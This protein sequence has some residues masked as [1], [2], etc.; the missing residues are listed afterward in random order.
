M[1]AIALLKFVQGARVG[2]DGHALIVDGAVQVDISNGG[3]N[4]DVK[5][6]R[7]EL[8]DGPPGGSFEQIPGVPTLLAENA[9]SSIPVADITPDTAMLPGSLRIRL[10]VWTGTNFGGVLDVD[11][12]NICVLTGANRIVLPPY[13][14]LPEPLPLLG[15][16]LPGEKPD[17]M[18]FEGQPWGW[19]GSN[20][21][22]PVYGQTYAQFRL[23]NAS[24][25]FLSSASGGGAPGGVDRD[26]QFNDAGVFG[27]SALLKYLQTG[28]TALMQ[29]QSPDASATFVGLGFKNAAAVDRG[30]VYYDEVNDRVVVSSSSAAEVFLLGNRVHAGGLQLTD[31]SNKVGFGK[32]FTDSINF[33]SQNGRA[34]TY[35]DDDDVPL[36]SWDSSEDAT[37]GA[38][39]DF[40]VG[41][42]KPEGSVSADVGAVYFSVFTGVDGVLDGAVWRNTDGATSWSANQTFYGQDGTSL[43]PAPLASSVNA[44]LADAAALT[45]DYEPPEGSFERTTFLITFG[46]P[47][48]GDALFAFDHIVVTQ[49][50]GSNAPTI[51]V[52]KE[53]LG[54]SD[55][56]VPPTLSVG[57]SIN[58]NNV[59]CTV[60][61]NDGAAR[62]VKIA[63]SPVSEP[64]V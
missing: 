19:S 55:Y 18:N 64:L 9:N 1:A 4:T 28:T 8:L 13:Q 10:S 25:A 33:V 37:N 49:R 46:Q 15:S 36:Q 12:R 45:M 26:V 38:L 60:T 35:S 7:V 22:H 47:G 41:N 5:S 62:F 52:E 20:Y 54:A 11:I 43:R 57:F 39:V 44:A 32:A 31:A 29:V 21:A 34:G 6:W 3:D 63:V 53:L 48:T 23:L 30:G 24:L 61:N 50:V 2:A 40:Y 59:R 42:R 14:L 27:A 16:G 56:S 17:E 51:R 58:G